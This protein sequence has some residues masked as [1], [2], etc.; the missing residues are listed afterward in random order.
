MKQTTGKQKIARTRA[1]VTEQEAGAGA[2]GVALAPPVY[3]V[4]TVDSQPLAVAPPRPLV[5]AKLTIGA[6]NDPY[7]READ[8][9]A[10]EV[11]Q[12]LHTPVGQAI[13]PQI[14]SEEEK[15]QM[16]PLLQLKGSE[17]SV[18]APPALESSIQQL[19]GHGQPLAASIRQPME[20]A[21]GADFNGVRVHTDAQADQLNQA[22]QAKA[23][24]TGQDLFFRQGAYAPGSREG[25]RL[26]AHELTHV[27][28]QNG[29]AVL[30]RQPLPE[31]NSSSDVAEMIKHS[32]TLAK[33]GQSMAPILAAEVK[34]QNKTKLSAS[35]QSGIKTFFEG[36]VIQAQYN[37]AV[38]NAA[39][40]TQQNWTNI[41]GEADFRSYIQRT[42]PS[43][44]MIYPDN[45]GGTTYELTWPNAVIFTDGTEGTVKMHVHEQYEGE[46]VAGGAWIKGGADGHDVNLGNIPRR[47]FD[48]CTELIN[49][50]YAIPD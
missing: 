1:L 12:R 32:A 29:S 30:K 34:L 33:A 36:K 45:F 37:S 47:P 46:Y 26:I 44:H 10:A 2:Q 8:R 35:L 18:T 43:C 9:V 21:F 25:Q 19:R 48:I 40:L 22:I 20:R 50:R 11:V 27:A 15:L 13:Q 5:Q 17:G 23:F 6:P 14:A 3:E 28:Q 7:E 24:T 49:S 16:K 4:E 41:L 31:A 38:H 42:E 39:A